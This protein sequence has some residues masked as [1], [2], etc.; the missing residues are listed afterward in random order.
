MILST[1]LEIFAV[2]SEQRKNMGERF[3][4]ILGIFYFLFFLENFELSSQHFCGSN[5]NG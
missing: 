3:D 4:F 5:L 1:T 2:L